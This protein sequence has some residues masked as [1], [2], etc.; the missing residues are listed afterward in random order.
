M[1]TTGVIGEFCYRAL[2]ASAE[3]KSVRI[4][5]RRFADNQ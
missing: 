1:L 4:S 5:V 2:G 3:R